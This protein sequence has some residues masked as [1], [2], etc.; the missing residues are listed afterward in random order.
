MTIATINASE[1]QSQYVAEVYQRHYERLKRYFLTQLG[2]ASQADDCVHETVRHLFFF[3]EDRDWEAEAEYIFVYLMRIAGSI[4][5]KRL[6]ELGPRRTDGLNNVRDS[7]F[8]KVRTEAIAT[9]KERVEF[10]RAVLR[11]VEGNG[12]KLSEA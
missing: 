6:G 12:R 8:N 9:M 1:D 10:I 5:S 2:D 11:P 3:M 4:C 7:L